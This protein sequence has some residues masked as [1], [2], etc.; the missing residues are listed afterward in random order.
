MPVLAAS[1]P[2]SSKTASS[3][4]TTNSLDSSCT[5]VTATVFCAV[6]ATSALMPWQPAAAKAFR[7]AWMPA[8]P[9][10][11]DVA[12]VRQRGTGTPLPSPVRTGSGSTGVISAPNGA[13]R[14]PEASIGAV[15][16]ARYDGLSE[17]YEATLLGDPTV[18][19]TASRLLG[20]PH[21]RL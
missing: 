14:S 8:P 12:M 6:S 7:S 5:A 11:S 2:M 13:P 20:P 21:G 3:C 10:E 19:D 9:P 1:T 17:W 18:P 4:A 15:T 16:R